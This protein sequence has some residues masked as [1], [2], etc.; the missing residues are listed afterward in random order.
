MKV[1]VTGGA[2]FIGSHVV[3]WLIHKGHSPVVLDNLSSGKRD[4]LPDSIPIYQIDVASDEVKNVFKEE[5]PD[6]VIH[7]AAQTDITTSILHPEEDIRTNVLGTIQLLSCAKEY[8]IKQFI[9]SSSCAVYGDH[10]GL[11]NEQTPTS[12][13]SVYGVSKLAA[14]TYIKLFYQLFGVPYTIFR[15]GNVYGPRQDSSGEGGVVAI[16]IRNMLLKQDPIIYGSG[17][18]TRDFVYVQDVAR[19]NEKALT[20]ALND[21]FTIGSSQTLSINDLYHLLDGKLPGNYSPVYKPEKDGDIQQCV[22]DH[23]KA[24]KYLNWT[25]SVTMHSGLDE[26]INWMKKTL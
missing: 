8:N 24:T 6:A 16:F 10:K 3:E 2:G 1:L 7:M 12:P 14:E 17:K 11:M 9:F 15:Y 21:T 13:I 4:H 20:S 25:P 26:T 5:Q 19:A 23:A 22:L 18:Q